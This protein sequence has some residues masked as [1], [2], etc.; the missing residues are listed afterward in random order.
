MTRELLFSFDSISKII[1]DLI[2]NNN[3]DG[4]FTVA[5]NGD[6]GTGKTT[7][8]SSVL[9]KLDNSYIKVDFNAWRFSKQSKQE[10]IWRTLILNVIESCKKYVFLNA[11][12]LGWTEIDISVFNELADNTEQAM[13]SAFVR[14][15]PGEIS[16]DVPSAIKGGLKL[17]LKFIPWGSLGSDLISKLFSTKDEKG[18]IKEGKFE[19]EDADELFS[20]FKKTATKVNVEKISGIEQF[21]S[22][23]EQLL[24]AILLGVYSDELSK[25]N[26]TV[27]GKKIKLI[28]AIDDLDRCLPEYSL[29]I[30]E[31]IK[32]FVDL[33]NTF[34]LLA[35][36]SN[37][38]QQGLTMRYNSNDL[39]H[40]RA[41]DYVEKMI[42]LSFSMPSVL[43]SGF[44]SYIMTLTTNYDRYLSLIDVLVIALKMNLRSWNRYVSRTEFYFKIL[45]ELG[46]PI[47]NDDCMMPFFLKLQCAS[48]QWPELYRTI[49]SYDKYL[50]F[51]K[52]VLSSP[53]LDN[54]SLEFERIKDTIDVSRDVKDRIS[55]ISILKYIAQKPLLKDL[56]NKEKAGVLFTFDVDTN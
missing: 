10:D 4:S 20:I 31:A 54:T 9:D 42:D 6:W 30:L 52:S 11:V 32:L 24:N 48:Y 28:V 36:D 5:L 21:R 29:D 35:M 12:K 27:H 14:E 40:I 46:S 8:L 51:E 13:Y 41:K 15:S 19:K 17:A 56:E 34:F 2:V 3:E 16:V 43:E 33:P 37:I 7:L 47:H 22:S 26:L 55:D 38:I 45:N 39:S 53:E 49:N 1:A 18:K 50:S 25:K 44:K 23:L